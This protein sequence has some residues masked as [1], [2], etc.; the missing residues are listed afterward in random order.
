V[1]HD[2]QRENP[3]VGRG[4]ARKNVVLQMR[5]SR[6]YPPTTAF[7]KRGSRPIAARLRRQRLVEHLHRLGPSPLGHF[8]REVEGGAFI[9]EHL[10]AYARIDP[11]FVH[12]LGG[13]KFA[14]YPSLHCIDGE[15]P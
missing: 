14:P 7:V 9:S 8:L 15:Q 13:D 2:P 10:E 6:K 11:E 1:T 5:Q 3:A 4:R 12:A